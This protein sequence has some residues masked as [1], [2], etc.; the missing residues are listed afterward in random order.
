[1]VD[2]GLTIPGSDRVDPQT[3]IDAFLG[4]A[5]AR[6]KMTFPSRQAYR[7]WW[8]RHPAIAAGDIEESDLDA[9][10]DY[11]LTGEKPEL[12]SAVSEAAVRDDA[13]ELFEFGKPA[14]R[15]AVPATLLSAPRGLMD[16]PNPMQPPELVQAWAAEAPSERRAIVIEDVNHYTITLGAR[17][18]AAVADVIAA[19][20]D[21]SSAPATA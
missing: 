8:R 1:L 10:A 6:L 19:A 12:R 11:D 9:Y 4:P 7:D 3:F 16:D 15:L 13:A 17:G 20:A 5:L 2:G 18:A 14:H 21:G